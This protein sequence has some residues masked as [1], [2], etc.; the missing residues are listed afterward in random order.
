M[1]KNNKKEYIYI[2]TCERCNKEFTFKES[3]V[4]ERVITC[5][6]CHHTQI[7]LKSNYE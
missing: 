6:H 2:D 3:D 7:F 4:K 5:P 1:K